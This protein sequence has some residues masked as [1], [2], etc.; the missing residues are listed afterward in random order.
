MEPVT[1]QQP[2]EPPP[3][4]LTSPSAA[5]AP[6]VDGAVG[7]VAR[8]AGLQ[9]GLAARAIA[10][11]D[12]GCGGAVP[13]PYGRCCR[14]GGWSHLAAAAPRHHGESACC[15]RDWRAER[16]RSPHS[17]FSA[18][19]EHGSGPGWRWR[20]APPWRWSGY[21]RTPDTRPSLYRQGDQRR[22]AATLGV[23]PLTASRY[24]SVVLSVC[25][26]TAPPCSWP[27]SGTA[28]EYRPLRCWNRKLY[29]GWRRSSSM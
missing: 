29:T 21:A 23:V 22:G 11:S 3:A 9:P 10:R 12:S 15:P 8:A 2:G 20:P 14:T 13:Q 24:S 19:V 5:P 27:V 28:A 16:P 26:F 25:R 6:L 4:A 1:L 18:G 7:T 17:P